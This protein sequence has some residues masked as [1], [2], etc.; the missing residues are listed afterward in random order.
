MPLGAPL[1]VLDVTYLV[2][3]INNYLNL[4]NNTHVLSE[5]EDLSQFEELGTWEIKIIEMKCS[6]QLTDGRRCSTAKASA[7]LNGEKY[8]CF[9]N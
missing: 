6:L 5:S 7:N 4:F 1:F 8:L 9:V 3:H 2:I